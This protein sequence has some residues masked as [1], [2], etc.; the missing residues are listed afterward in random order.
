M[1]TLYISYDT[2]LTPSLHD[3]ILEIIKE[4]NQNLYDAADEIEE[5]IERGDFTCIKGGSENSPSVISTFYAITNSI[6]EA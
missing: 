3:R 5:E 4:H 1:N 6:R 2:N